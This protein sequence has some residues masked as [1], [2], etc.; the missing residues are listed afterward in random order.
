MTFAGFNVRRFLKNY[1]SNIKKS[2]SSF[3]L[4]SSKFLPNAIKVLSSEQLQMFELST[5]RKMSSTKILKRRGHRK[6]H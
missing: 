6:E 2:F 3:L 5:N 1:L 4:T